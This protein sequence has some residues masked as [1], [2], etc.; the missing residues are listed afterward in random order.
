MQK[1]EDML[2][3]SK[4]NTKF[5]KYSAPGSN[6]SKSKKKKIVKKQPRNGR[7]PLYLDPQKQIEMYQAGIDPFQTT[8]KRKLKEPFTFEFDNGQGNLSP[9]RAYRTS[10]GFK[11]QLSPY[12][13]RQSSKIKT[14]KYPSKLEGANSTGRIDN[15][16]VMHPN[17]TLLNTRNQTNQ[18]FY[19]P[20]V[21]N[22]PDLG[23]LDGM[24]SQLHAIRQNLQPLIDQYQKQNYLN[25]NSNQPYSEL[26]EKTT[27]RLLKVQSEKLIELL[28]EDLLDELVK[29]LNSKEQEKKYGQELDLLQKYCK[30]MLVDVGDIDVI[31]RQNHLATLKG[32]NIPRT[33]G[34][35]KY[36]SD[37]NTATNGFQ[38]V[39]DLHLSNLEMQNVQNSL[40]FQQ[41]LQSMGQSYG[42]TQDL[43]SGLSKAKI[44]E[45]L[46]LIAQKTSKFTDDGP[47]QDDQLYPYTYQLNVQPEET[48]QIVRDQIVSE[49]QRNQV[50]YLRKNY[51]EGMEAV[52]DK[53][54]SEVLDQIL[55]E[56]AEAQD[57]FVDEVIRTELN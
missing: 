36:L 9:D 24:H 22:G 56:V 41:Q 55:Q 8:Q 28:I 5:S 30:D 51:C 49:D 44:D 27:G 19:Q 45:Q 21:Q 4:G 20:E 6:K 33:A 23:T 31:Q 53:M 48:M 37:F 26:M 34:D 46:N 10:D 13:T 50:Q 57:E 17:Q 47:Y 52:S 2:K 25:Q 7:P 42:I 32:Q 40:K 16:N 39:Q 3:V 43:K 14:Q 29:V 12:K 38:N 18:Q 11:N 35:F 15:W 1:Y 54:M